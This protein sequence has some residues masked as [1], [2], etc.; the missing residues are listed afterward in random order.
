MLLLL[1]LNV[2]SIRYSQDELVQLGL[3]TAEGKL[4]EK[5]IEEWIMRHRE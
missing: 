1:R 3:R 5:D 4:N 2:Y